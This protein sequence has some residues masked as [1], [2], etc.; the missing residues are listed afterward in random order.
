MISYL[1]LQDE[2]EV[3]IDRVI[4]FLGHDLALKKPP[5]AEVI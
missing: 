3:V 2:P 1:Q 5:A 4:T